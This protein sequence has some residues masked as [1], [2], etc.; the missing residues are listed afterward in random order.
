MFKLNQAV[1][2]PGGTATFIGYIGDGT[3]VQ[4]SRHAPFTE[5][6]REEIEIV[7]P[8]VKEWDR[9]TYAAWLKKAT[10]LR[11]EIYPLEAIK[12]AK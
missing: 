3:R 2:T 1:V 6:T 5:L 11:N 4:V 12:E 10:F 7:K 9:E 8:A